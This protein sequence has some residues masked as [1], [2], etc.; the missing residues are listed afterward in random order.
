MPFKPNCSCNSPPND[1][2]NQLKTC[3]KRA[4][5]LDLVELRSVAAALRG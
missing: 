3:S 5:I 4:R 1:V 2:V